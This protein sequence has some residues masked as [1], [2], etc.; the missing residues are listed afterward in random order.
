M[1][2]R[3]VYVGKKFINNCFPFCCVDGNVGCHVYDEGNYS[4]AR[5]SY[6][7]VITC[8]NQTEQVAVR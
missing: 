3:Y 7:A 4:S 5:L 1:H 2:K 6:K 8:V